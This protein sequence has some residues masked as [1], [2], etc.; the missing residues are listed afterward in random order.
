MRFIVVLVA[1]CAAAVAATRT[2]EQSDDGEMV[3]RGVVPP[4][5]RIQYG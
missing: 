2:A 3:M 1:R 5:P 4:Q